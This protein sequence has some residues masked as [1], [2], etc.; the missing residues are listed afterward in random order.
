MKK[1]IAL[2]L[3]LVMVLAMAACGAAPATQDTQPAAT[4]GTQPAAEGTEGKE[5]TEAEELTGDLGLVTDNGKIVIGITDYAPMDYKD[6]N[7]EWTGFDAELARL[8]AEELG[9]ECEF[10]VIADW[11]K[12]FMELDTNSIDA[13]WNGMTITEEAKANASVSNPYVINAQVVV[14]KADKVAQYADVESMKDLTFAVEE[15]SA[16]QSVATEAGLKT[17]SKQDQAGALMEVAAGAADACV[18]DITMANAMTGE[19]Q[20]ECAGVEQRPD[21]TLLNEGFTCPNNFINTDNTCQGGVLHQGDDLIAHRRHNTLD[22]LQQHHLEEDLCLR[23]TQHL[24]GFILTRCNGLNATTVDLR[25]IASIIQRKCHDGSRESGQQRQ[26]KHQTRAVEDH[27]QL[28]H[29]GCTTDY[30]HQA[31]TEPLDGF[32]FFKKA[33]FGF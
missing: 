6:E 20:I 7:G 4:Q 16:G 26:V 27:D 9:V 31:L 29:Q 19:D 30:P 2:L 13:V 17:V 18:I 28:Q 33:V 8:F 24:A 23:H 12:K 10:F 1:L 5:A 14:M 15:G 32:K 21:K 22:H 25:K 11:G 3:A